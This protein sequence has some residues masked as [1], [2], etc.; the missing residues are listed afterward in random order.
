MSHR[1]LLGTLPWA[2]SFLVAPTLAQEVKR[3][4]IPVQQ[5]EQT[6]PA[7]PAVDRGTLKTGPEGVRAD[8]GPELPPLDDE[9]NFARTKRR[10]VTQSDENRKEVL[11]GNPY[12]LSFENGDFAP[13]RGV[14]A[15][16]AAQIA[17]QG[18]GYG[19]IMIRGRISPSKLRHLQ[20]LGIKLLGRHTWQSLK[21]EIPASALGALKNTEFV[22]WVGSARPEQ[23]LSKGLAAALQQVA[24]SDRLD[25]VVNLFDTDIGPNTKRVTIG[26]REVVNRG[27]VLYGTG[28]SVVTIPNGPAQKALEALGFQF[29]FYDHMIHAVRGL[30]TKEQI[31]KIRDLNCVVAVELHQSHFG[32]HDQ[33]M[34]M[35]SQDRVRNSL[36]GTKVPVGVIDTGVDSTP[37]HN[38]L[39]GKSYWGWSTVSGQS[40]W[41]DGNGHGTH[42]TCTIVGRG[43]ADARYKGAAPSVGAGG[44]GDFI[45]I[46]RYLNDSGNGSG[47]VATLYSNFSQSVVYQNVTNPRPTLVNN[48]WGGLSSTGYNGTGASARSVDAYVHTYQQ[49]YVFAAGN[50]GS[51]ANYWLATPADAKNV[52]AVGSLNDTFGS[53]TYPGSPSS[54]T[55]YSTTDGRRK[56]EVSAPG[57][58]LS[59]ALINT[60][61][62]YTRKSGTSMAS[63]TCV[64]VLA[65]LVDRSTW[66]QYEPALC[67]A[68]MAAT[69]KYGS[70]STGFD[71]KQGF[72]VINSYKA[73]Y[74]NRTSY[75]VFKG[76]I[77]YPSSGIGNVMVKIPADATQIK[78]VAAWTEAAASSSATAAVT[79]HFRVWADVPPY[80]TGYSG[81]WSMSN[82]AQNVLWGTGSS[83]WAGKTVRF[84]MQTLALRSGQRAD[85]GV[86][87][88]WYR[89]SGG[90]T[91]VSTMTSSV[92]K[93]IIKPGQS[94]VLTSTV[95]ADAN[96]DEFNHAHIYFSSPTSWT[97][98]RIDRTGA[99]NVLQTYTGT[100][101]NSY[102]YPKLG[103]G[104]DTG[105]C[106]G[107]GTSRSIKFTMQAPATSGSYTLYTRS[108]RNQS[109]AS[110]LAPGQTVC[111]DGLVPSNLSGLTANRSTSTWYNTTSIT[112]SWTKATDNGCSG[113]DNLRYVRSDSGLVH[114]TTSSPSL[115]AATT[116]FG[117]TWSGSG[118][119]KYFAVRVYDKAGNQ[120]GSAYVGPFWVDLTVP[121]LSTVTTN[122]PQVSSL[123]ANVAVS[124]S[125][126]YSGVKYIQYSNN[127]STWSGNFAYT[128]AYRSVSLSAYGGNTAEG[129][130]FVYARLVDGAGNVSTSQR[131]AVTY[132]APPVITS[133]STPSQQAVNKTYFRFI[134]SGFTETTLVSFGGNIATKWT[135]LNEDW[136]ANGAFR[137]I[138][139]TEIW[140]FP[141]QGLTPGTYGVRTYNGLSYSNT[142]NVT[143]APTVGHILRTNNTLT[144]GATQ[145]I[146][147]TKDG[148]APTVSQQFVMASIYKIPS[149]L[150]GIYNFGIGNNFTQL[151]FLPA[152]G[153]DGN[154]VS[155]VVFPTQ[156]TFKGV[157]GYFQSGYLDFTA[158][159][160]WPMPASDVW[161]TT[162]K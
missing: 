50:K 149:V 2:F 158:N 93:T 156:A 109:S 90:S 136:W 94:V 160:V 23:K 126:T 139:D 38:D 65:S 117:T 27:D 48:S 34:S 83:T 141:I 128:T 130:K 9:P 114:P 55:R 103:A 5:P 3:T 122:T 111:V 140:V 35:V 47:N 91:N 143:V 147:V 57:E 17:T 113:V 92:D 67:K 84:R 108:R 161:S 145:T 131:V 88:F 73:N 121:T 8:G 127:N 60:S 37:W 22:H 45:F 21:A 39:L 155:T 53:T 14:D 25:I 74:D 44:N 153:F 152:F 101:H 105:M 68:V 148:L 71:T 102:P 129:T 146:K 64:G 13:E 40:A 104:T 18:R 19:F 4:E 56:P 110:Y 134:G 97:N 15:A 24:G 82:S 132:M 11:D 112:F 115:S 96:Y 78:V 41:A 80:T 7:D 59:S 62:S 157:T 98:T 135:S 150:P 120:S 42:V 29:S 76:S 89:K 144:A 162:Y 85:Y 151:I 119:N 52:L 26:E 28:E 118:N 137:V 125:D 32:F 107:Q 99:D 51:V 20:G 69:A 75:T 16:L 6:K 77:A 95:T 87:I 43:A 159:V 31:L 49:C 58:Q 154:G 72:G 10:D 70:G 12:V 124:G 79:D 142:Q 66:Y 33:T 106:V 1:S 36:P 81:E 123:N 86:V 116:G 63:P 100:G 61:S 54:F 133:T 138:S 46:G 30:A